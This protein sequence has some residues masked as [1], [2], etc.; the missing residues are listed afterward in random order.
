LVQTL[1]IDGD[2]PKGAELSTTEWGIREFR[3]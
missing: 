1:Y 3:F 2:I